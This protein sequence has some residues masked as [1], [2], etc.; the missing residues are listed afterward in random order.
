[1]ILLGLADKKDL[2]SFQFF[3]LLG[4]FDHHF[5]AFDRFPFHQMVQDGA[6]RVVA[7]D[8]NNN[9]GAIVG[10]STKCVKLNRKA[11]FRSYSRIGWLL[12]SAACACKAS[13]AS[14]AQTVVRQET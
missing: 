8:A 14:I 6:K 1:M 10:H 5:A 11:A 2:A 4:T 7:E 12:E 13:I 9:G 3:H